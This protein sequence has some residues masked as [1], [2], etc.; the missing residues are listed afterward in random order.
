MLPVDHVVA[1]EL[2]EGAE[3]ETVAQIPDGKMGL[4]IG[5]KTIA[6]YSAIIKGAKT[7][8]WNGPMGVFEKPPFDRGTVALAKAVAESGAISVVGGGDSEK[9]IKS[10]GVVFEDQPYFDRRRRVARIP[11][12]N[13][14]AGR[15]G[16]D[17]KVSACRRLF[18]LPGL[19]LR[20]R[21]LGSI[22]A[23]RS[24]NSRTS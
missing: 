5:D 14:I 4:D 11:L 8:V 20:C 15:R 16:A 17:R 7:I 24:A 3:H 18:L 19:A 22:R 6:E 23:R 2:K 9:A 12:G 21:D 10:A 13:R 1:A